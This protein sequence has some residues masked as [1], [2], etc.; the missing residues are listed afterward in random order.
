MI[1]CQLKLRLTPRQERQLTRWFYHLTAIWNWGIKRIERDAEI[2]TYYSSISFRNLLNGHGAK[3]GV[4]QDVICGTLW[5]AHTA[6]Q[7]CFKRLAGK[8]RLKGRRNRLRSITFAHG[9]R[10][11][12]ADRVRVPLL[13]R[14]R[15]HKQDIP[16]GRISQIRIVKR[17]S[18]WY[19]CLFIKTEPNAVPIKGTGQIG[20]D[21][22]FRS[23]LTLSTGEKVAHPR[24][25][26]ASALRLAQSQR[27]GNHRQAARV[28]ERIS[29][30]RRDRNHKLSRRLVSENELIAFSADDHSAIAG[31]FGKSVTSSGHYQ[32]R[33][34][35]ASKMSRRDGGKYIEVS[36]RNSTKTC[37]NCGA[38]SGPSGL[39]ALA[40]RQWRCDCGSL[41]DRDVNAAINTLHAALGGSVEGRVI[42]A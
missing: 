25:L 21:P 2:G 22:G 30:Q 11:E 10:I 41:N 16:E 20:I 8:P 39:S 35:L 27:G 19:L 40:V 5:T 28:Q 37:S 9:T 3:I 14:V 29:N 18:G 34:M 7:R 12:A 24:E 15:F 23:L 31:R 38:F 13:G 6:W 26:E 33:Q 17:A 36:N 32:L 1:Q 4:P 42:A